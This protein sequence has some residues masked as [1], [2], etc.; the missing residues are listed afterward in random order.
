MKTI[1]DLFPLN[2][3]TQFYKLRFIL[4]L[5]FRRRSDFYSNYVSPS[6]AALRRRARQAP[7]IHIRQMYEPSL[8]AGSFNSS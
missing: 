1:V 6:V 4:T 5:R 3:S 8:A 7:R 2:V